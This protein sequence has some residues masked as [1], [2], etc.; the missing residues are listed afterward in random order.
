MMSYGPK[1]FNKPVFTYTV[2]GLAKMG[3][4]RLDIFVK[5]AVEIFWSLN[6]SIIQKRRSEEHISVS[7]EHT[8]SNLC[9]KNCPQH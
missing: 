8:P 9:F 6:L 5:L 3:F 1:I 2:L 4:Y 7:L